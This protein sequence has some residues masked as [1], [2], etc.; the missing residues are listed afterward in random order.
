METNSTKSTVINCR[1][2]RYNTCM[3]KNKV[4]GVFFV[5]ILTLTAVVTPML[6][7]IKVAQAETDVE[8]KAR[9][10]AELAGYEAEIKEK[11]AELAKQ[12]QQTGSI[13]R[14]VSILTT[15][16]AQAKLKIKSRTLTIDKL[17][18]DIS[19][20]NQ[21]I[22]SLDSKLDREKKSLA[23]LLRK[24]NE[25]EQTTLYHF[26]LSQGDISD[27]Y[28]EIDQYQT[29]QE[30]VQ[31]SLAEVRG[32]K[33]QTEEEKRSLETVKNKELDTKAELEASKRKVEKSESEKKTLL[34][35]SK[36]K[37]AGYNQ[38][39]ADR[40]KKAASIRAALFSLRDS[41]AI[42]FGTAYDLALAAEAKTGVRSA[43]I[44]AILTQESALGK[45]VGSCVIS[46][47]SSGQTKGVNTGTIF[48]NGIHPTRDLP[49]LQKILGELGRD[50][51][52]TKVSCPQ[53][54]GYGG[55]MG[56]S[57]F[58]PSTWIMYASKIAAAFST[59]VADPWNPRDAIMASALFLKDLGANAQ[60]YS[61]E[62]DAA[63]RYYSGRSC[64]LSTYATSYGNSVMGKATS[65]QE[66][67]IDPLKN[68]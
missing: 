38:I 12:K 51:L 31:K 37:E 19:L 40:R 28:G 17:S 21:S 15:E 10:E 48:K 9:L 26:L 68:L 58:I 57:Q 43:F 14:D 16:I 4:L 22:S 18:K 24:T 3:T 25:S 42:P 6:T 61:A 11:E 32:I 45:N 67:Q 55:A 13:Q 35:A 39:L 1:L 33:D 30:A 56:P 47:L 27:L 46:D 65:I 23:Q 59:A 34:S 54:I 52:T 60:T 5:T 53:S 36:Q 63:C 50:P 20:K 41:A 8:R 44:L 29:I 2:L 7:N 49:T 64:S 66:N 62:R